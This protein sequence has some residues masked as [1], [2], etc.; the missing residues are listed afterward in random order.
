MQKT[1]CEIIE[2]VSNYYEKDTSRRG[3]DRYGGCTYYSEELSIS[4]ENKVCAI[5]YCVKAPEQIE[6]EISGECI[7]TKSNFTIVENNFKDEF[8]GHS[9]DFWISLQEF[10][11]ENRNWGNNSLTPKGKEVKL[12]L[13]RVYG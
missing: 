9:H 8:K 3:I 6:R 4:K 1:I 5:G 10:H 7:S 2:E 12:E 11:D 13:R